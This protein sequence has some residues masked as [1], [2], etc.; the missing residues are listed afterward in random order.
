[1]AAAKQD[2]SP[3]NNGNGW[4]PEPGDV[5]AGR[6]VDMDMANSNYGAYPVLTIQPQN[7]DE[8]A[9]HCF[10]NTLRGKLEQI[11]PQLGDS[12]QVKYV[13]L[14]ERDGAQP[15]H[16]YRVRSNVQRG[17]F[18]GGDAVPAPTGPASD[19]DDTDDLP[20]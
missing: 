9:I 20:F 12:I 17:N 15:Y 11:Q 10:H 1:M 5:I 18:W 14:I 6:I 13:G 8:I 19:L 3:A 2:K 7:G 16:L 4:R